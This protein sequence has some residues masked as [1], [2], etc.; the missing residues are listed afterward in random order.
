[1]AHLELLH[2][3][4]SETILQACYAVYRERGF[5]FLEGLYKNSVAVEVSFLGM[6]VQR[7][8][9]FQL[10]HRGQPVGLY[11]VDLLIEGCVLVE[12]KAQAGISDADERQ[13][14]N[15]LRASG[16][17]VG[18]LFNFGPSPTFIRRVYSRAAQKFYEQH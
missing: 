6:R 15:Y 7:E 2:R 5:G 8:V 3:S 11:R 14:L 17:E 16:I 9:P 1:M 10:F 13:L 4:T 12:I 18:L